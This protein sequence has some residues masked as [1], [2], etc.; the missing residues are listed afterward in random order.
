[1][2]IT[3]NIYV[4]QS[5][6]AYMFYDGGVIWN[7]KNVPG[8][9]MKQ[10]ITSAGFGIRFNFTKNLSGNLMIAQPLTKQVTAEEV[11]GQGRLPRSFFSIVL[12]E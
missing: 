11:I 8:V 4:L 12:S 9:L 2:D 7:K 5:M 10:S 3:P 1:M 6:Q